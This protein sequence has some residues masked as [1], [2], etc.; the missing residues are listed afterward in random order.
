[1]FRMIR[2]LKVAN[3]LSNT[4]GQ[5]GKVSDKRCLFTGQ[6]AIGVVERHASSRGVGFRLAYD[7]DD[8][9]LSERADEISHHTLRL[10]Q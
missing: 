5:H 1:M 2:E 6:R 3:A 10:A 4:A 9:E 7:A 8:C